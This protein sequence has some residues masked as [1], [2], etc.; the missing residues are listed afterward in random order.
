MGVAL[1]GAASGYNIWMP[2]RGCSGLA[3]VALFPLLWRCASSPLRPRRCL[4]SRPLSVL[5]RASL[6]VPRP[7][8]GRRVAAPLPAV[9]VSWLGARRA[10]LVR[11]RPRAPSCLPALRLALAAS[12]AAKPSPGSR[13]LIG[14]HVPRL[15]LSRSARSAGLRPPPRRLFSARY[16]SGGPARAPFGRALGRFGPAA[17]SLRS[18]AP[19]GPL[20]P[21]S[22]LSAQFWRLRRL[23]ARLRLAPVRPLRGPL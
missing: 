13:L 14:G 1:W 23:G 15:S 12:L 2:P 4:R 9:V 8:P 17:R 3:P 6:P 21:P 19:P 11:A 10:V 16:G 5:L 18:L 20:P 7:P 22:L